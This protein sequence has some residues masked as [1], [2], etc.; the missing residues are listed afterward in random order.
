DHLA[1]AEL[2]L[3]HVVLRVAHIRPDSLAHARGRR[4]GRPARAE[5]DSQKNRFRHDANL[6][7]CDP[8]PMPS[9][10]VASEYTPRRTPTASTPSS[11]L[12]WISFRPAPVP[13]R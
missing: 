5:V 13:C 1:A 8:K 10:R 3:G 11:T 9:S 2:L 4:D 12:A 6:L 7:S